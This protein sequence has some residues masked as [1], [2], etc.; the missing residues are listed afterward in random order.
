MS[1]CI[2]GRES[3]GGGG[4]SGGP[5]NDG[6]RGRPSLYRRRAKVFRHSNLASAALDENKRAGAF[7]PAPF[8]RSG[9]EWT[10]WFGARLE[11]LNR[12]RCRVGHGSIA[13]L[14]RQAEA[15]TIEVALYG[16]AANV[17]AEAGADLRELLRAEDRRAGRW[18]TEGSGRR[19]A[20][21]APT[22]RRPIGRNYRRP[23]SIRRRWW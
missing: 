4:A 7:A 21:R 22:A 17:A 20:R 23:S 12:R 13:A 18:S 1:R 8:G 9:A 19:S 6:E 11:R 16:H 5:R 3:S 14:T 2:G 15:P 10:L